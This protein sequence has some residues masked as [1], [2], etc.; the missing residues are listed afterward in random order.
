MRIGIVE[1]IV[2]FILFMRIGRCCLL[3]FIFL[4][5]FVNIL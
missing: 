3:S 4:C 5:N 2:F 1:E